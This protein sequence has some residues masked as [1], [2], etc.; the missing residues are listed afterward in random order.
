[1]A[2]RDYDGQTARHRR[3]CFASSLLPTTRSAAEVERYGGVVFGIALSVA[4]CLRGGTSVDVAWNIDPALAP[5]FDPNA[6]VAITPGGGRLGSLLGG[7]LDSR[8]LEVSL[9]NPTGAR[10]MRCRLDEIEAAAIGVEEGTVLR[11]IHAPAESLPE[12][13]WDALLERHPVGLRAD[14]DG[15]QLTDVRITGGPAVT[16]FDA[17]NARLS[18]GWAPTPNLVVFGGGPMAEALG[19]AAEFVG[20][21]VERPGGVDHAVGVVA[22]QSPID[23]VVVSGHDTEA[24]GRVLQASLDSRAGYIGSI[25]PDA[26]QI[27]RGDWLAYRG[28]TDTSRVHAPAGFDIGARTPEEVAIS[29]VCEMVQVRSNAAY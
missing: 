27:D 25:G 21:T 22:M 5:G 19:R 14:L 26:L 29:V 15:D 4:A 2:V 10:I 28:I 6:A 1:M 12:A 17:E 9:A 18:M 11:L 20:W 7:A 23:G 8:L 13:L 24:V 3:A 16:H